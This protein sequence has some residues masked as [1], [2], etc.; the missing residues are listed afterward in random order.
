[1]TW[2]ITEDGNQ[3]HIRAI[4]NSQTDRQELSEFVAALQRRIDET[5]PNEGGPSYAATVGGG[6]IAT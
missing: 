6:A 3:M 5:K 1:M 2:T 4:F